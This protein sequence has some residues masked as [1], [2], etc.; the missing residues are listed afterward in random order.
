MYLCIMYNFITYIVKLYG[1]KS[2][3]SLSLLDFRYTELLTSSKVKNLNSRA[4][5]HLYYQYS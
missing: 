2:V 3:K 5:K 1:I 4:T